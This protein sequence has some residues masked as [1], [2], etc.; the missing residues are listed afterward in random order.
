[1]GVI[2]NYTP[3]RFV[4]DVNT[5]TNLVGSMTPIYGPGISMGA[6][7]SWLGTFNQLSNNPNFAFT[8]KAVVFNN[9]TPTID[10][11]LN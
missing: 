9:S 4:A 7:P 11:L 10:D 8:L 5:L 6:D 1:M 3:A 2:A